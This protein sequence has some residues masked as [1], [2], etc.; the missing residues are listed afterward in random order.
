[1]QRQLN[2]RDRDC[3]IK[4]DLPLDDDDDHH[5]DS[6]HDEDWAPTGAFTA[7]ACL[8]TMLATILI[9]VLLRPA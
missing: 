2:C 5:G 4:V 1:M 3:W 9:W 6:D 7:L 8:K